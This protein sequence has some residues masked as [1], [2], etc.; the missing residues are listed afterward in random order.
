MPIVGTFCSDRVRKINGHEQPREARLGKHERPKFITPISPC[1]AL[2]YS[3]PREE[4]RGRERER[5]RKKIQERVGREN[6]S[7]RKRK[8]KGIKAKSR[9]GGVE[10]RKRG[11]KREEETKRLKSGC[12]T[13]VSP[14]VARDVAP[15]VVY[16]GFSV[17]VSP[18]GSSA[19]RVALS[20]SSARRVLM[21]KQEHR[22]CECCLHS[23]TSSCALQSSL[24]RCEVQN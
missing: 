15:S 10:G 6:T 14:E 24:A 9:N 22:H 8:K 19:Q 18:R 11:R 5:G 23:S 7:K 20:H 17:C 12:L 3:H 13:G 2:P 21:H 4:R 1:P 16:L